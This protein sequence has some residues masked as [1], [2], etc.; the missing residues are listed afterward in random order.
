V[1]GSVTTAQLADGTVGTADLADGA[2]TAGKIAD[3]TITDADVAAAHKDGTAG[4]PS[5]RT[6]GTGAQQAAAG[7]H[8]HS[9]ASLNGIGA[10]DHHAQ[11]HALSGSDHTGTLALSQHPTVPAA[12]VTG[13]S[14]SISHATNTALAYTAESYD[15]DAMHDNAT[16]NSR[17]T[18]NTAG[19]YLLSGGVD[20]G[21]DT[22]AGRRFCGLRLN[23]STF[24]KFVESGPPAGSGNLRQEVTD[25]YQ[26]AA[27]DYVEV[28]VL[29][30]TGGS[31]NATPQAFSA[32]WLSA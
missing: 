10:N 13:G 26:L 30:S 23:G 17:L 16:N 12:R 9:H 28:V 8:G 5:L 1:A 3:V 4:T 32:V 25:T 24:V 22:T 15:T 2:V 31:L 6:L 14:Q 19:K 27:S 21:T 20:W 18:V 7:N 29:Q 11:A